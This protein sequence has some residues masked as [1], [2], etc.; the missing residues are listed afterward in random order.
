MNILRWRIYTKCIGNNPDE[1]NDKQRDHFL[2]NNCRM[3]SVE[4]DTV[5]KRF[6]NSPLNEQNH[7]T[8]LADWVL[9]IFVNY[10]SGL[11]VWN[12][13]FQWEFI[14]P[15]AMTAIISWPYKSPKRLLFWVGKRLICYFKTCCSAKILF[16][17]E[18]LI[19]R[20]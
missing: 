4:A 3:W 2:W 9:T 11:V 5:Q 8:Q 18:N 10:V 15:S 17:C 12:G 7:F 14:T 1:K 16:Y 13:G 19:L 20:K 6:P